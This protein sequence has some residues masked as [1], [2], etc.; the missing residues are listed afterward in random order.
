MK[1]IDMMN[2]IEEIVKETVELLKQI[3]MEED[4]FKD[5]FKDFRDNKRDEWSDSYN[6]SNVMHYSRFNDNFISSVEFEMSYDREHMEDITVYELKDDLKAV[7]NFYKFV[8]NFV[9]NHPELVD[10]YEK[11][12]EE[13]YAKFREENKEDFNNFKNSISEEDIE[14]A[15][16]VVWTI[17]EKLNKCPYLL[18]D[19]DKD[20]LKVIAKHKKDFRLGILDNDDLFHILPGGYFE[21]ISEARKCFV[22]RLI[23]KLGY[24]KNMYMNYRYEE[25]ERLID[26]CNVLNEMFNIDSLGNIIVDK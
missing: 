17:N 22:E 6:F 7:K 20:I 26:A 23:D 3:N 11:E 18:S 15:E 1:K 19:G 14:E 21:D 10:Q 16:L 8:N 4:S 9:E 12:K 25:F 24:Y 13:M 5:V 2:K